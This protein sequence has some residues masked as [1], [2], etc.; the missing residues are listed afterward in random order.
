MCITVLPWLY[1]CVS[2][3]IIYIWVQND[4][5]TGDDTRRIW[6]VEEEQFE[7]TGSRRR[8]LRG[9]SKVRRRGRMRNEDVGNKKW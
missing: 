3:T 6:A 7:E 8:C 9:I 1:P 5:K 4:S 2:R